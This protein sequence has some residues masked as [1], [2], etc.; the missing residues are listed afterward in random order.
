[1]WS[2][3]TGDKNLSRAN[4]DMSKLKINKAPLV[5]TDITELGDKRL[6]RE[7]NWAREVEKSLRLASQHKIAGQAELEDEER[8]SGPRLQFTEIISRVRREAPQLKVMDGIAGYVALYFPRNRQEMS[9]DERDPARDAFF[10]H[11]KYVGGMPKCEL[12]E[13]GHILL[14]TSFLPTKEALRG[15][16]T[17]LIGLVKAGVLSY[18]AAVRQFGEATGQR[19]S[20]WFEALQK[21]KN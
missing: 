4:A 6:N 12:P 13:Y 8:S 21:Y 1:M 18:K 3:T 9:E 15:W 17:V 11:H 14:D 2:T 7:E 20:R 16:R 10:Y 19:S 5:V